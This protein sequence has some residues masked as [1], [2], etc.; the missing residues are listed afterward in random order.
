MWTYVGQNECKWTV[1]TILC[2][3]DE[4]TNC[5]AG[6]I[7]AH[8][9][10]LKITLRVQRVNL[11]TV[12]QYYCHGPYFALRVQW[13]NWCAKLNVT[14][15][16]EW[17]LVGTCRQWRRREVRERER[18]LQSLF[19]NQVSME[20]FIEKRIASRQKGYLSFRHRLLCHQEYLWRCRDADGKG[21]RLHLSK[22]FGADT[23]VKATK[24]PDFSGNSRF[25]LTIW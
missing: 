9:D 1:Q 3:T 15:W 24:R 12:T 6:L 23:N 22:S 10:A 7:S 17:C 25:I 5:L 13:R 19:S 16:R 11:F 2:I 8:N 20:G 4:W 21:G 18:E 14:A